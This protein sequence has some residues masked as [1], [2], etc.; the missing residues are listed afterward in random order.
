MSD[1]IPPGVGALIEL[2]GEPRR[3]F[4]ALEY[5]FGPEGFVWA[6]GAFLTNEITE[7]PNDQAEVRKVLRGEPQ[8]FYW[9]REQIR[10]I[11]VLE[12][13]AGPPDG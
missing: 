1:R 2:E 12:E 4:A 6:R 9:P 8:R 5:D 13:L 10:C 11:E 7:L 3:R